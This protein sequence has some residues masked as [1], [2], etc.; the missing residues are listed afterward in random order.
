MGASPISLGLSWPLSNPPLGVVPSTFQV[1]YPL[2]V[3]IIPING[4]IINGFH[5]G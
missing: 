2:I 5:W 1:V 4:L 3:V